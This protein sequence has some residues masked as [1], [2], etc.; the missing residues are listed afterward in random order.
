MKI[1]LSF[2]IEPDLH[3]EGY[4]GITE[5]IPS[6]VKILDRYK[7]KGTFFVTCDCIEKY[8][9]I[10]QKLV[11]EGHEI[12]LHAY[13][14]ERFDDLSIH[15][16]EEQIKKSI[17]CFKKILKMKPSGFRAPQHSIDDD[18]LSLLGKYGFKYD[19]SKTPLNAMQFVFFPTRITRNFSGFFSNPRKHRTNGL[20]EIPPTSLL[21]PFVSLFVRVLP[22]FLQ[23]AYVNAL[24]IL[25]KEAIFY[26]HSWDFIEMKESSVDKNF[27]HNRFIENLDY[28]I[29][30][31]IK[32]N[33]FVK[34]EELAN[35]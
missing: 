32:K 12:S 34:I 27:S 18:A 33:K 21:V 23:S 4:D 28:L 3:T 11:K 17:S 6:I 22:K 29:R 9:K 31:N 7:I 30:S 14:H 1:S 19:S 10:F 13:R 5:G 24:K 20:I 25:F 35:L 2:D 8:P 26:A 15:E 16:K